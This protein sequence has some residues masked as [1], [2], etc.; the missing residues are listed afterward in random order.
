MKEVK[1][2]IQSVV[3]V[4]TNS[5]TEIFMI[6]TNNTIESAKKLLCELTKLSKDEVEKQFNFYLYAENAEEKYIDLYYSDIKSHYG[7]EFNVWSNSEIIMRDV[8]AGNLV[9]D[10]TIG[11]FSANLMDEGS[12]DIGVSITT[13]NPEYEKYIKLIHDLINS[14]SADT[15]SC[16]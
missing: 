7:P 8:I 11:E 2:K 13:E 12:T 14:V 16:C 5:S 6:C 4:I 3:D 10:E 15:S 1:I 9:L